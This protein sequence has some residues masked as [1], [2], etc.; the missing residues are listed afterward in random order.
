MDPLFEAKHLENQMPKF[1]V[2]VISFT[3]YT[4]KIYFQSVL[5]VK[6]FSLVEAYVQ[7]VGLALSRT[8]FNT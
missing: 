5:Y 6:K 3:C 2:I 7:I 1:T 8:F 4:N